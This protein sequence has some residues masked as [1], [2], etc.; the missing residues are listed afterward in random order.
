MDLL[1][2]CRSWQDAST[3]TR[4]RQTASLR[5]PYYS[6]TIWN[7][8]AFNKPSE[9]NAFATMGTMGSASLQTYARSSANRQLIACTLVI[10]GILCASKERA[11]F[12]RCRTVPSAAR[13]L[14]RVNANLG[15]ASD[16]SS[17]RRDRV[18]CTL[19]V[20]IRNPE[21]AYADAATALVPS[22]PRIPIINDVCC[23]H[24]FPV[25]GPYVSPVTS[26]LCAIA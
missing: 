16:Y 18:K 5:I 12:R 13:T 6:T 24:R 3:P 10:A 21:S 22:S 15:R 4:N 20:R 9:C 1:R 11:G 17:P 23:S 14:R 25:D 2:C 7:R 19:G 8:N 26:S